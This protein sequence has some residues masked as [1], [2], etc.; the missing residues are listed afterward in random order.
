MIQSAQP[1]ANPARFRFA[2]QSAPPWRQVPTRP[3]S[4]PQPVIPAPAPMA[5]AA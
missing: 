1:V 4:P 5:I 2:A 3:I